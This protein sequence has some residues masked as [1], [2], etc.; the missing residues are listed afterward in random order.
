[1]SRAKSQYQIDWE[2]VH[3]ALKDKPVGTK[4]RRPGFLRTCGTYEFSCK[5]IDTGDIFELTLTDKESEYTYTK[6]LKLA[7]N[8]QSRIQ[9]K[10]R[11][12]VYENPYYD[13][14]F[15]YFEKLF[16]MK[17]SSAHSIVKLRHTIETPENK[18]IEKGG[19][20]YNSAEM[21]FDLE[22]LDDD[23]AEYSHA[24][25]AEEKTVSIIIKRREA[26]HTYTRI[27]TFINSNTI[28]ADAFN[29]LTLFHYFKSTPQKTTIQCSYHRAK[30]ICYVVKGRKDD[31]AGE[32]SFGKV[33]NT[34]EIYYPNRPAEQQLQIDIKDLV[35]RS[36]KKPINDKDAKI[37]IIQPVDSILD[38]HRR[39]DN[40]VARGEK[41]PNSAQEYTLQE[42]ATCDLRA[43]LNDPNK[44]VS[45]YLN[46]NTRMDM[47]ITVA[48]LV[49]AL[50]K[51][52]I[53][54]RDIKPGNILCYIK[55]EKMVGSSIRLVDIEFSKKKIDTIPKT[56][57]GTN[58]YA[59]NNVKKI[60]LGNHDGFS[61]ARTILMP[62]TKN[63]QRDREPCILSD[64][65]LTDR[66]TLRKILDASNDDTSQYS[67]SA[68][69]LCALI[70]DKNNLLDYFWRC[71]PNQQN[72]EIIIPGLLVTILLQYQEQDGHFNAERLQ[73][74]DIRELITKKNMTKKDCIS[75]GEKLLGSEITAEIIAAIERE[76]NSGKPHSLFCISET[77]K[78]ILK[79]KTPEVVDEKSNS[80]DSLDKET[81]KHIRLFCTAKKNKYHE[82][83]AALLKSS[84]IAKSKIQERD[85][86]ALLAEL[87][88]RAALYQA[89]VHSHH[90]RG[91][92]AGLFGIHFSAKTK[93]E[94]TNAII[95]FL[96]NNPTR[97]K[98]EWEKFGP[99]ASNGELGKIVAKLKTIIGK[100]ISRGSHAPA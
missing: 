54:H 84:Y 56:F 97:L 71:P 20:T 41:T 73:D 26:T 100:R 39:L 23:D 78:S 60:N 9:K 36:V 64:A 29:L 25:N 2:F 44:Y 16:G 27:L 82:T 21:T 68:L 15:F 7:K 61:L 91:Y 98:I 87:R 49:Y 13:L 35:L 58:E 42:K 6:T 70:L 45:E 38:K 30:E 95:S 31:V 55:D 48:Q 52:D 96:E 80:S 47:A 74:A 90:T 83:D 28:S 94:T 72:R 22:K 93:L 77:D 5:Q 57:C 1:M 43:F 34:K 11:K 50:H 76:I 85:R 81:Y 86:K 4:I 51:R 99:A 59:P 69:I 67:N 33:K 75:L 88:A 8:E 32:G 37:A 18:N 46:D 10:I 12:G 3:E 40:A 19:W 14:E 17:G 65:F 79:N 66:P 53:A 63:L 89:R 62:R 24:Y 92:D